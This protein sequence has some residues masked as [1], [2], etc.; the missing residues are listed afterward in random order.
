MTFVNQSTSQVIQHIHQNT[1]DPAPTITRNV[2]QIQIGCPPK[3]PACSTS[4]R[5]VEEGH[6]VLTLQLFPGLGPDRPVKAT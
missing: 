6:H 1:S 3:C 4:L 5:L 2:L